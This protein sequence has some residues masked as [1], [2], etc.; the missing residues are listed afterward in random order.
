MRYIPGIMKLFRD[1]CL[2]LVFAAISSPLGFAKVRDAVACQL[3]G[4]DSV[5]Y[6]ISEVNGFF[7]SSIKIVV[8]S[9]SDG[10]FDVTTF[11]AT[12]TFSSSHLELQ[13]GG[14][15]QLVSGPDFSGFSG[16]ATTR[17]STSETRLVCRAAQFDWEFFQENKR[18]LS[19]PA[20]GSCRIL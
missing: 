5:V 3:P 20:S 2:L 6:C 4:D 7:S 14:G 12:G 15:S 8:T 17:I 13:Y 1:S 18:K 10:M 11:D 19:E 16:A 9:S